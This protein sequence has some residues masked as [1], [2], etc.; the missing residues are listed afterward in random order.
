MNAACTVIAGDDCAAEN[1]VEWGNNCSDDLPARDHG[2]SFNAS[3]DATGYT[4]TATFTCDDGDFVLSTS[5]TA[6]CT[7]VTGCTAH[8]DCGDSEYCSACA[9]DTTCSGSG[10]C[11]SCEWGAPIHRWCGVTDTNDIK[12]GCYTGGIE[13][14]DNPDRTLRRI[15]TYETCTYGCGIYLAF[16]VCNGCSSNADCPGG[17]E[18]KGGEYSDASF[19]LLRYCATCYVGYHCP[20]TNQQCCEPDTADLTD[21]QCSS[22][23]ARCVLQNKCFS[24]DDC[25]T[26]KPICRYH[27]KNGI[28]YRCEA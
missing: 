22:V 17:Q 6:T 13:L 8:S 9:A 26:D 12:E 28:G 14:F 18:C 10:S 21:N 7:A 20:V 19:N 16:P 2:E 24:G 1:D 27:G 5:T 11:Q 25:P 15:R 3:N 23:D 4:G